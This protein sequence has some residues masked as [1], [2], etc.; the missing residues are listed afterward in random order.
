VYEIPSNFPSD[1]QSSTYHTSD[2]GLLSVHDDRHYRLNP[3][4]PET[5]VHSVGVGSNV[6]EIPQ[7]RGR[8]EFDHGFQD[9]K[10]SVDRRFMHEGVSLR[11]LELDRSVA[12]CAR[13]PDGSLLFR[14]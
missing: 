1:S 10:R 6:R 9:S 4:G 2:T 5:G 3:T 14:I 11:S 8:T 7:A 12:D 13:V